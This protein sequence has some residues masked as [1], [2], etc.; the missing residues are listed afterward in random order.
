MGH[1]HGEAG[2]ASERLVK[3]RAALLQESQPYLVGEEREAAPCTS[4]ILAL[5]PKK[6]KQDAWSS[7]SATCQFNPCNS[8]Q[9]C[10]LIIS[11][12]TSGGEAEAQRR[13]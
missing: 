1:A 5:H 10:Q 2:R 13:Q 11:T 6:K 4:P 3:Q 7:R 9:R 8:L 12:R